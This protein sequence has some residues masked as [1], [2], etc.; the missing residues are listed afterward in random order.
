VDFIFGVEQSTDGK[1][2]KGDVYIIYKSRILYQ[3]VILG[4]K[5]GKKL[6]WKKINQGCYITGESEIRIHELLFFD[7]IWAYI[8][9]LRWASSSSLTFRIGNV[10]P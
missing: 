4:W 6:S 1:R 8:P 5:I 10:F 3:C 7:S 2:G 9:V